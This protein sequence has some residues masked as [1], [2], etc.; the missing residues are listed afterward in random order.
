MEKTIRI[1][2][3]NRQFHKGNDWQYAVQRKTWYGSW[4]YIGY[5]TD[6]GYGSVYNYYT[7]KTKQAVLHSVLERYYKMD[8]RFV[9]I[10]EYPELKLH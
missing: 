1:R 4:K 8:R 9:N 3:V 10:F 5:T 7:G 2:F 6:M